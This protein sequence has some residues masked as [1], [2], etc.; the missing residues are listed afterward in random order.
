MARSPDDFCLGCPELGGE[1]QA[2]GA[3]IIEVDHRQTSP[4]SS[5]IPG[6]P[7]MEGPQPAAV[8]RREQW[9][10]RQPRTT[11]HPATEFSERLRRQMDR[12]DACRLRCRFL[13]PVVGLHDLATNGD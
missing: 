13:W 10:T 11:V 1:R 6:P 5:N 7:Q 9:R 8:L 12:P 2:G 3:K 4:I